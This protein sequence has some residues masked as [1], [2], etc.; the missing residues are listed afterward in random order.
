MSGMSLT[1][2]ITPILMA[3]LA[4]AA[5]SPAN[6]QVY[7][8]EDE[9][10]QTHISDVPPPYSTRYDREIIDRRGLVIQRLERAKTAEEIAAEQAEQARQDALSQARAEQARAD[11]ILLQSFGS[12]QELLHARDD[13]ISLIDANISITQEK[14]DN[15]H[16]QVRQLEARIQPQI[17]A[18]QPAPEGATEQL[19]SLG[20]QIRL[21]AQYLEQRSQERDRV[22]ARFEQDLIRFRALRQPPPEAPPPR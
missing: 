4:V 7:R 20:R 1:T 15:L 5:I 8:W 19:D 13:R 14:L 17:A 22:T 6:G 21:Q 11:W 12:E 3:A 16:D 9:R 10:G 2:A 18:G